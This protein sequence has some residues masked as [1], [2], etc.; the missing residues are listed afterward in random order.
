ML[1]PFSYAPTYRQMI[2]Y[3]SY[4]AVTMRVTL[5][6]PDTASCAGTLDST[7]LCLIFLHHLITVRLLVT[8]R[9]APP[10]AWP[11]HRLPARLI[12]TGKTARL[13]HASILRHDG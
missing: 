3:A 10:D 1:S 8:E 7:L 13:F 4:A 11:S 6:L 12:A 2:Q 9:S 5:S